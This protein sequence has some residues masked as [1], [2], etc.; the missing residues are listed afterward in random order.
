LEH[1]ITPYA[2]SYIG[3]A[4]EHEFGGD[5]GYSVK[6]NLTAGTPTLEGSTG[7]FELGLSTKHAI[8]L[9]FF[10]FGLEGYTRVREGF[11]GKV[12]IGY[13]F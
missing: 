1:A 10:D 8:K 5:A 4:W 2:L 6:N 3:A 9:I 11:G 7:V 13:E 12:Q